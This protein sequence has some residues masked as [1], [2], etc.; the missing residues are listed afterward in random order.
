MKLSFTISETLSYHSR[1]H[2]LFNWE[3]FKYNFKRLEDVLHLFAL[4][5]Y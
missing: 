3:M 5:L 4:F 2:F 1:E